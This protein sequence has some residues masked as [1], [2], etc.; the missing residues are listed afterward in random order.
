MYCQRCGAENADRSAFCSS[1][2]QP[3][4]APAA[5]PPTDRAYLEIAIGPR[6]TDY[7]VSRFERFASGGSKVSWNWPAFF[8]TLP[9]LLYRK[10]W[11][12]AVLYFFLPT[13]FLAVVA[14]ILVVV[15]H[16]E[17]T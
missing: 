12:H 9:W 13:V 1:C 4:A 2:G 15:S 7:Y 6:N 11:P 14:L 16:D 5:P 3:L 8:V 17:F 10:M